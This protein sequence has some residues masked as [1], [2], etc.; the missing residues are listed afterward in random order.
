MNLQ[1]RNLITLHTG[2]AC[3]IGPSIN[4]HTPKPTGHVLT[5]KC[6]L[7]SPGQQPHQGCTVEHKSSHSYGRKF[8]KRGGGVFALQ[9]DHEGIQSWFFDR[10][11]IPEDI[12]ENTPI[13]EPS[14]WWA[15]Y[16][17]RP[18]ALFPFDGIHCNATAFHD[19]RIII[20]LTFCGDWA[21]QPDEFHQDCPGYSCVDYVRNAPLPEAY[22]RIRSVKVYQ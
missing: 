16:H 3:E 6:Q 9:L 7:N 18:A 20:N 4:Q 5:S 19:L 21:G 2:Q 22:W 13:L 8:N 15:D 14:R 17:Y 12:E 1:K 11:H 10:S